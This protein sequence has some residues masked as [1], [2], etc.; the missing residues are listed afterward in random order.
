MS[1]LIVHAERSTQCET[2]RA[3]TNPCRGCGVRKPIYAATD[4]RAVV[5][6]LLASRVINSKTPFFV[7]RMTA[8]IGLPELGRRL[9]LDDE[10]VVEVGARCP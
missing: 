1:E 5:N 6:S 9:S 4:A 10:A 7:A 8:S 2:K 3:K